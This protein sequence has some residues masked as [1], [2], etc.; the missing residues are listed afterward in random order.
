MNGL[1]IASDDPRSPDI[2]ELLHTHLTFAASQSP[3]EDVHAL[4]TDGLLGPDIAF[5]S[6]R[7]SNGR[8]LGIGAIRELE[9][10]HGE[11][12]SMHTAQAARGLG[13]GKAML[14]HLLNVARERRY[15]RVSLE[16]GTM[17][18]FAPARAL[19]LASGFE[20]CPPFAGYWDSPHS[21]CMTMR[22]AP[23]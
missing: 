17:E 14:D 8:L 23:T 16:T 6:V 11:I 21:V 19:Y 22:L 13:I 9:P 3:P 10:D 15:A 7:E 5:F 12:K 4:D 20:E 18:A 1:V 2:Q